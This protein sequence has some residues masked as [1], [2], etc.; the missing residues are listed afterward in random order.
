M[1]IPHPL[2]F[3]LLAVIGA[4][5]LLPESTAQPRRV[6]LFEQ[7]I[8]DRLVD[9]WKW[10][11]VFTFRSLETLV[12]STSE[13]TEHINEQWV[14]CRTLD[15]L[16]VRIKEYAAV[17]NLSSGQQL[18]GLLFDSLTGARYN[19]ALRERVLDK[20]HS[21]TRYDDQL[22]RWQ[23]NTRMRDAW[24]QRYP[25]DQPPADRPPLPNPLPPTGPSALPPDGAQ[26][27]A[28]AS[29]VLRTRFARQVR[30]V[31]TG[32]QLPLG[33]QRP[34]P[35]QIQQSRRR[36]PLQPQLS[37]SPALSSDRL[38]SVFTGAQ[39]RYMEHLMSSLAM[40][41]ESQLMV[42]VS[43]ARLAVHRCREQ[44]RGE[45]WNCP[46]DYRSPT[47]DMGIQTIF[48]NPF[49]EYPEQDRDPYLKLDPSWNATLVFKK[50]ITTGIRVTPTS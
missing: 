1:N 14:W 29:P 41:A 8:T 31:A 12:H 37:R 46:V 28:S 30:P 48:D 19:R 9:S 16:K 25:N 27:S 21:L 24:E 36:R 18:A 50:M 35:Q 11:Y 34:R 39:E 43:A 26:S 33:L 40:S 44:F 45:L 15:M 49:H 47:S 23:M 5:A 3:L 4:L 7:H 20:D 2:Q 6:A 38:P 17:R 32:R 42:L 22:P 10:W 13:F